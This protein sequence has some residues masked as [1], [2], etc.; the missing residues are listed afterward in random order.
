MKN[1]KLTL[2]FSQTIMY[3]QIKIN[4]NLPIIYEDNIEHS[5]KMY[6]TIFSDYNVPTYQIIYMI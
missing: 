5:S 2:L 3:L 4:I 1:T 6:I